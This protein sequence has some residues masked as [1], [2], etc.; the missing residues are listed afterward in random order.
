MLGISAPVSDW[1][2]FLD[3]VNSDSDRRSLQRVSVPTTRQGPALPIT[4][5]VI[6]PA[7]AQSARLGQ[8]SPT[9]FDGCTPFIE[10]CEQI[11]IF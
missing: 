6:H 1:I 11:V 9:H 3:S 8:M 7:L 5:K 2:P 4:Q 10:I